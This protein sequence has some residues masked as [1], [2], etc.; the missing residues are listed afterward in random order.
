VIPDPD[1]AEPVILVECRAPDESP[2]PNNGDDCINGR[3]VAGDIKWDVELG[4]WVLADFKVA[5]LPSSP[6]P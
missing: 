4:A 6:S 5:P 1:T 2:P 3:V